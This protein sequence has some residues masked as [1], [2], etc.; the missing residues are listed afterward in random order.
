MSKRENEILYVKWLI[1]LQDLQLT[2]QRLFIL[3]P[4]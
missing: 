4:Q 2:K 3:K 1:K